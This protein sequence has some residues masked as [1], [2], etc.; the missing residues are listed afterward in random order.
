M[1]CATLESRQQTVDD[2]VCIA[3]EGK[4]FLLRSAFLVAEAATIEINKQEALQRK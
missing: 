3:Q 1:S 4:D 2:S